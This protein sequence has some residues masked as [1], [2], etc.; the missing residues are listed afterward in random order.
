MKCVTILLLSIIRC[1]SINET[2]PTTTE[3][4]SDQGA[5]SSSSA[6]QQ[7]Y[8]LPLQ[9]GVLSNESS[10]TAPEEY[11]QQTQPHETPLTQKT[12]LGRVVETKY[13]KL[14]GLLVTLFP[15]SEKSQA[16]DANRNVHPLQDK[17]I[18][19]CKV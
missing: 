12:A 1:H 17:A 5:I 3:H 6:S 13:G 9:T 7:H 10:F 14:Q 19:V 18:E 11:P 16:F 15:S 8:F 4:K 2:I